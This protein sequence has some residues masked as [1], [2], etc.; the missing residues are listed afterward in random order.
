MLS[1]G[2]LQEIE[3]SDLARRIKECFLEKLMFKIRFGK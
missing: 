3:K 2:E 1:L